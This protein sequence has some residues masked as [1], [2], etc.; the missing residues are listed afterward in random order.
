MPSE[1]ARAIRFYRELLRLLPAEFREEYGRELC[2]VLRDRCRQEQSS[3]G[4]LRVWTHA[5]LEYWQAHL[6]SI[7]T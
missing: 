5:V 4:F 6:R 1:P 7:S 3:L 2:L